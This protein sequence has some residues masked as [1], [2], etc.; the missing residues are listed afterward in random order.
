MPLGSTATK[1]WVT[2]F[3]SSWNAFSAAFWPAESPSKVK[4]T[5]PRN[6]FWSISSR[7]RILMCSSPKAV[8]QVATAVLTPARWQAI[9]S[10]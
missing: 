8:P 2:N 3:W 4:T 10:V 1:V 5:S 6:S 7:R 9:T